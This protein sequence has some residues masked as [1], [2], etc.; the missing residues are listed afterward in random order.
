MLT[1]S[2]RGLSYP[3]PATRA[4]RADVPT[5]IA[6]LIAALE[7]DV[8]F[9]QGTLATR[10]AAGAGAPA[11]TGG[12]RFWWATD[13]SALYYDTGSG[14]IG[15]L[16]Q[17]ALGAS[18]ITTAMLQDDS[19]TAAKIAAGAVGGSEIADGAIGAVELAASLFP[20]QGAGA[21]TEAFRAIGSSAGQ[22]MAGNDPRMPT[23]GLTPPAS[24]A[25]TQEFILVDS[26]TAPTY[27]WRLRYNAASTATDKWDFI[28]G[29][30][31]TAKSS[32]LRTLSISVPRAGVYE[33]NGGGRQVVSSLGDAVV[34]TPDDSFGLGNNAVYF[35]VGETAHIAAGTNVSVS[36]TGT[37]DSGGFLSLA[38][39]PKRLS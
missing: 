7:L 15:P 39:R 21:G 5:D 35:G 23:Y 22:V 2:R 27:A 8:V 10:P 20:S 16:N 1:S 38:V 18:S 4:D 17:Q 33:W 6:T 24:P 31:I 28:G 11:G 14:W 26:V 3:N 29:S 34:L 25:D 32:S 12:G 30:S 36:R 9:G 37:N 13:T 19:V